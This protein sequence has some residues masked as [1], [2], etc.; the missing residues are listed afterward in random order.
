V[1]ALDIIMSVTFDFPQSKTTL[2]RQI[3]NLKNSGQ[4]DGEEPQDDM[5]PFPFQSVALVPE[6]EACVY[7]TQS[8]GVAFQSHFPRL[9]HWL[10][11]QKQESRRTL[12]LRKQLISENIEKGIKRLEKHEGNTKATMKCAVD[13]ILLR[14]RMAAEKN[15]VRPDFHKPAIYDEVCF[16]CD[17]DMR[18]IAVDDDPSSFS[19]ILLV[20]TTQP[21]SHCPGGLN[22]CHGTGIRSLAYGTLS[23]PPTLPPS[24]N[25]ASRLQMRLRASRSHILMQ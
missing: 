19:V 2:V 16:N 4:S 11:L 14:E 7:L 12:R 24:P 25:A 6:L 22:T 15:G 18:Q 20:G 17:L 13:Q 3:A 8:I 9:A 10:Y 5:E 21:R 23:T 1:A